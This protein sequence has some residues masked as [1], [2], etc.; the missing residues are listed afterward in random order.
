MSQSTIKQISPIKDVSS[1]IRV[2]RFYPSIK[3]VKVE[4]HENRKFVLKIKFPWFYIFPYSLLKIYFIQLKLNEHKE[5][6][7]T[8]ILKHYW[9]K[10]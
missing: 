9:S 8:V 10:W 3:K 7:A 4:I 6:G 2:L 5:P 1:L